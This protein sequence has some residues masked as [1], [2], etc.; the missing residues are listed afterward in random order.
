M[1]QLRYRV[2]IKNP[3]SDVESKIKG[4]ILLTKKSATGELTEPGT[5][6]AINKVGPVTEKLTIPYFDSEKIITPEI[7]TK[8]F[9][10]VDLTLTKVLEKL[11]TLSRFAIEK[12]LTYELINEP[13]V[14][15]TTQ[16]DLKKKREDLKNIVFNVEKEGIFSNSQFGE[17]VLLGEQGTETNTGFDFGDEDDLSEL[18]L[19]DEFIESQFEGDEESFLETI[20][21]PTKELV[22]IIKNRNTTT[23]QTQPTLDTGKEEITKSVNKYE[24]IVKSIKNIYD[25]KDDINAGKPLFKRFKGWN[26]DE[27]GAVEALIEALGL[28]TSNGIWFNSLNISVL[29]T[30]HKSTFLNQIDA[31]ARQTKGKKGKFNF[32]I[33]NVEVGKAA[34]F[35]QINSNF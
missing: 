3:S 5:I 18:L 14:Q 26:D 9:N 15:E 7:S 17:L 33:P 10:E 6:S 22:E 32:L 19:D 34:R 8:F 13:L 27:V 23:Q 35:I 21:N 1:L 24:E 11:G 25:L 12:K 16:D 4:I 29:T 2:F 20:N 31:L 28:K 30:D